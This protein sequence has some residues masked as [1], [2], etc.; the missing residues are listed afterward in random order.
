MRVDDENGTSPLWALHGLILTD[1]DPGVPVAI[2][3]ETIVTSPIASGTLLSAS[4]TLQWD[5]QSLTVVSDD[6]V[7]FS[8][9]R[10]VNA[11]G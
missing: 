8:Q 1:V 5:E 11:T 4:A 7:V 9:P 2:R 6:V 3:W 10:V